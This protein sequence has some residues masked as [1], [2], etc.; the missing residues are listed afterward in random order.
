MAQAINALVREVVWYETAYGPRSGT[1]IQAYGAVF[2]AGGR[3]VASALADL[4]HEATHLEVVARLAL[5][6]TL[7]N[8]DDRD[9]SPYRQRPRPLTRVLHVAMVATRGVEAFDRC[10][11]ALPPRQ[12][13]QGAAIRE[14]FADSRTAA[15]ASLR[16]SARWTAVGERLWDDLTATAVSA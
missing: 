13:D 4:V 6:P 9:A 15:L 12:R 8:P 10:L 5:E 14:E 16:R 3:T 11:D 2:L 7:R 1:L